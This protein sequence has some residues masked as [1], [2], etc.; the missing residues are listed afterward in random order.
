MTMLTIDASVWVSAFD[1]TDELHVSC[2]DF[3]RAVTDDL[4]HLNGP[5]FVLVET[6]CA[7]ARR[8]G[9]PE[10]GRNVARAVAGAPRLELVPTDRDLEQAAIDLGTAHALRV[11][12]ALYAAVAAR[13]G[14]LLVTTDRE[15]AHRL[16]PTVVALTPADWLAARASE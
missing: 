12:D 10:V 11:A 9:A 14:S 15:L 5:S 4:V 1:R 8:A 3:L 2:R 13:T 7:V 16:A 6:A